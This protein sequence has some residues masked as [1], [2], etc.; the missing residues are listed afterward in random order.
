MF[1]ESN[2]EWKQYGKSWPIENMCNTPYKIDHFE[3]VFSAK[4]DK[5]KCSVK[6]VSGVI[7]NVPSCNLMPLILFF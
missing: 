7:N 5:E 4:I 1:K 2:N 6:A 3:N